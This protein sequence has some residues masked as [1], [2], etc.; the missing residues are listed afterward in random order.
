[1]DVK[2]TAKGTC[3]VRLRVGG[4]QRP[5]FEINTPNETVAE[6]RALRMQ[7]V[8]AACV[9]ASMSLDER[10]LMLHS[11][12]AEASEADFA[13]LEKRALL[14]AQAVANAPEAAPRK[15]ASTF[16]ELCQMW[17]SG[18]LTALYPVKVPPIDDPTAKKARARLGVMQKAIGPEQKAIGSVALRDFTEAHADAAIAALPRDMMKSTRGSH[19]ALI[20]R[21]L[22]IAVEIDLIPSSPLKK[23]WCGSVKSDRSK[24]FLYP[25]DDLRLVSCQSIEFAY[26]LLWGF[27]AREGGRLDEALDLCWR[28]LDLARGVARIDKHKSRKKSGKSRTWVMEPGTVRA[29]KWWY[30][31]LQRR[32]LASPTGRVFVGLEGMTDKNAAELLREVH[33][34]AAGMEDRPELFEHNAE[35]RQFCAHMLR[36]TFVTLALAAGWSEHQIMNKTGHANSDQLHDYGAGADLAKVMGFVSFLTP[37]DEALGLTK[38]SAAANDGAPPVNSPALGDDQAL[39]Q[40]GTALAARVAT[41]VATNSRTSGFYAGPGGLPQTPGSCSDEHGAPESADLAPATCS[42]AQPG[43]PQKGGVATTGVATSVPQAAPG[44]Q[45]VDYETALANAIAGA[46]LKEQWGVVE[47]LSR[48]LGEHQRARLAPDVASLSAARARKAGT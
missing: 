6:A 7:A 22:N 28:H 27:L 20:R 46:V 26:R 41:R 47:S 29:L 33:L 5:L 39:P 17:V 9:R 15:L 37:L 44:G 8:A 16:Q 23:K 32:E 31:E 43:P 25:P 14:E 2:K 21:V 48:L 42:D 18:E 12:A 24:S 1:M 13:K 3:K 34:R 45:I 40:T 36:D 10:Q 38:G 19:Q 35:R 30:L 4:K 11:M